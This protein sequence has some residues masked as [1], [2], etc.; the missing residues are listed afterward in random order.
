[1]DLT[2]NELFPDYE[3]LLDS[4]KIK[5]RLH[6]RIYTQIIN[7][8]AE[9]ILDVLL[10]KAN[11]PFGKKTIIQN[12]IVFDKEKGKFNIDNNYFNSRNVHQIYNDV[13]KATRP[14]YNLYSDESNK[15]MKAVAW[16]C[17][18]IFAPIGLLKLMG[19]GAKYTYSTLNEKYNYPKLEKHRNTANFFYDAL[20]NETSQYSLP[21]RNATAPIRA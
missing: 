10:D 15:I 13:I 12:Y 1:M 7:N 5:N 21:I 14:D 9:Q 6:N 2:T 20:Y 19:L 17:I 11:K 3:T 16:C 18:P 8:S 4:T